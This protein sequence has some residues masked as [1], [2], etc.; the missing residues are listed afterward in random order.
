MKIKLIR[1]L[2]G[3]VALA[4]V[5]QGATAFEAHNPECIAPANRGG[6]WDFTCREVGQLLYELSLIPGE[7]KVTNMP[8]AG[9]GV[10]FEYVVHQRPDDPNL[11]VAAS[12]STVTQLAQK[13]FPDLDRSMVRWLAAMGAD[14]GVIAV[15]QNSPLQTLGD[16]IVAMKDNP[17]A[18][19]AGGGSAIFGFDHLKLLQIAKAGGIKDLRTIKY[20]PFP[21]GGE[22]L[23]QVLNGHLQVFSGDISEVVR[24]LKSGEARA[25]AVL[26]E[27]RLSGELAQVPTAAEQGIDVVASNWRGFYLPKN[28]PDDAYGY[29]VNNLQTVY[30]SPQWRETM[31]RSGLLPFWKSGTELEA[32]VEQQVSQLEALSRE[33]GVIK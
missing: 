11:L 15:A 2:V 25:L 12:T 17:D 22:A 6:G 1:K 13:K 21:G 30:E 8:G 19:D 18:V 31:A 9:G 24:Y 28:A 7:M 10:A 33:V 5:V 14:F 27:Q 20:T 16:L 23:L 3:S 29:W 4:A 32:M 26:W